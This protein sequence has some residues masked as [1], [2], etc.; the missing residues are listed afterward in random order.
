[1]ILEAN[2]GIERDA[3][4]PPDHWWFVDV[5]SR[6]RSDLPRRSRFSMERAGQDD[7][8]HGGEVTVSHVQGEKWRLPAVVAYGGMPGVGFQRDRDG[9]T[10]TTGLRSVGTDRPGLLGFWDRSQPPP[11]DPAGDYYARY[12]RTARDRADVMAKPP[13]DPS[14]PARDAG[15]PEGVTLRRGTRSHPARLPDHPRVE[16]RKRRHPPPPPAMMAP[17]SL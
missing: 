16:P 13:A 3:S 10:G 5:P 1:M 6:L 2:G 12:M 7:D 14:G 17:V 9:C 15:E 4:S 11:P 8:P